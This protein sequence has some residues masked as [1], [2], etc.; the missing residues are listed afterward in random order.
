[1]ETSLTPVEAIIRPWRTAT[2]VVAGVAIVEAVLVIALIAMLVSSADGSAS[3][4]RTPAAKKR[5]AA[6][7][8]PRAKTR[9][10]ILNGNGRT[11]AAAAEA[12]IVKSLRYKVAGVGNAGRSDY[13]RSTVLYTAGRA[14]EARRLAHDLGIAI[15]GPLDGISRRKLH[16]AVV[17]VTLG[18]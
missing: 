16:G 6:K 1:V 15:V 13:G 4:A 12:Q 2:L 5:H 9:V 10:L 11:G 7:T 3:A 8:L 17:A 18:R 14:K